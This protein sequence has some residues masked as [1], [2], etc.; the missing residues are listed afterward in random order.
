MEDFKRGQIVGAFLAEASVTK[1][2]ILGVTR[3]TVSKVM[4]AYMNHGKTTSVKRS[5]G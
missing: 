3:V 1:T 4:L 2:A 5:S